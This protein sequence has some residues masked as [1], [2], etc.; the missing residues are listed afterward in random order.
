MAAITYGKWPNR[1]ERHRLNSGG[2]IISCLPANIREKHKLFAMAASGTYQ[3]VPTQTHRLAWSSSGHSAQDRNGGR[4]WSGL[5]FGLP[6][7]PLLCFISITLALDREEGWQGIRSN[8][9]GARCVLQWSAWWVA[10]PNFLDV[11][12]C[13]FCLWAGMFPHRRWGC[14]RLSCESLR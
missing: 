10:S 6:L 2:N 9:Q 4:F 5:T 11:Y 3:S 14:Y 13:P 1:C 7:L 8:W 12:R